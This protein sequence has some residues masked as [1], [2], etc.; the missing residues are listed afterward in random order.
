MTAR[1][2]AEMARRWIRYSS[3][4]VS[5]GRRR[6][7]AGG[8]CRYCQVTPLMRISPSGTAL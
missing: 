2:T 4:A 7:H 8:P 5:G 6:T 3:T 1:V